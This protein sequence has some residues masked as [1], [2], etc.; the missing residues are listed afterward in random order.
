MTSY[1]H[2]RFVAMVA[3]L[4]RTLRARATPPQITLYDYGAWDI[5]R[6]CRARLP[7]RVYRLLDKSY[8]RDCHGTREEKL[9]DNVARSSDEEYALH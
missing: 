6:D 3:F 4:L 5:C 2:I 7:T 1:Y 8:C 9:G